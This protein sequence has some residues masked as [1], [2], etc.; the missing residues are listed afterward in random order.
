MPRGKKGAGYLIFTCSG[1]FI[2]ESSS[3]DSVGEMLGINPKSIHTS[4]YQD[5]STKNGYVIFKK[6]DAPKTIKE[7]LAVCRM[8]DRRWVLTDD[9]KKTAVFF[10]SQKDAKAEAAKRGWKKPNIFRA[11]FVESELPEE[12]YLQAEGFKDLQLS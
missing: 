9:K 6:A 5:T 2:G 12:V 11:K 8:R 3:C 4:I 10:L 1:K 7:L